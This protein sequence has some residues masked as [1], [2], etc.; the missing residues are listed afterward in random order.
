[1]LLMDMSL[2]AAVANKQQNQGAL[3]IWTTIPN[4]SLADVY[5]DG[6]ISPQGTAVNCNIFDL[7]RHRGA[8]NILCADGHVETDPILANDGTTTNGNAIGTG[9]NIPSGWIPPSG[10]GITPP[11]QPVSGGGS[12]GGISLNKGFPKAGAGS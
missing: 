3:E 9:A 10:G 2:V 4:S 1:M 7:L 12:F 5:M 8:A 11:G 6:G